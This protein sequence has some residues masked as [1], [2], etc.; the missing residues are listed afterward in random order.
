M[1]VVRGVAREDYRC[2]LGVD[3]FAVCWFG[4]KNAVELLPD[5]KT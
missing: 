5:L 3:C 2:R 1:H 4:K